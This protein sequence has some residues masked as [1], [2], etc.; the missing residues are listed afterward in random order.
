[1][2]LQM[3]KCYTFS[4]NENQLQGL[5]HQV[6]ERNNISYCPYFDWHNKEFLLNILNHNLPVGQLE[7][8]FQQK[9]ALYAHNYINYD[10]FLEHVVHNMKGII[11]QQSSLK[12]MVKMVVVIVLY[13]IQEKDLY[14]KPQ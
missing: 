8:K 14:R 4:N 5:V 7:L 10:N 2:N 11:H 6:Q 3:V 1:M 9:H 13:H 12:Y